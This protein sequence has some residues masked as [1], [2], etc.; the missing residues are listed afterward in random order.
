MPTLDWI[1]KKAVLNH[2]N[3]VP[4][5][6]L[7]EVPDLSVG[8][9]GNGN[10]LVE[11]D[12]LVA[13]KALLPYYAG[14]VK[15]IFIDPPYNSGEQTWTYNDYVSSPE[16]SRWL[17]K[18]VG[19]ESEDLSRHDKWLC[20]MYPRMRLLVQFLCLD[21]VMFVCLDDAE[22]YRFKLMMEEILPPSSFISALIWK[23]RR[24][25]DSRSKHNV[26]IDHEYVLAF[27]LGAGRFRGATK[28]MSKYSNPDNDP[29]GPWMSDN[30]VGLAT[31][32]R[33]PNLHYD[34]VNPQTGILYKCPGKGWRYSPE[35]MQRKIA[36]DRIIWPKN[37]SGRP[38]HK[39][40]LSDLESEFTG[41][42][43]FI[44]CGNTNE[45]T[46]EVQEILG[47][48]GFIF[49][50]PRS[51]IEQLVGQIALNENDIIM[52][53]FA[54]SGTTG[55]AVLQL[56]KQD[57]GNRRFILVEMDSNICR[58]VTAERLKRVCTGYD[59]PDGKQVEGLGGGFRYCKLGEACFDEV[60]RINPE[61]SFSDLARHV[62]F[63]ETGE[64]IMKQA[65]ANNPLI[66]VYKETAVY[67][68]YN[69]VLGDKQT[70]GGNVLTQAVLDH[71]PKHEG[72]KV[73]YGTACRFS[74]GRLKRENIVFKQIP[75]E[76]R[77]R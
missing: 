14:K 19:K 77:V 37:R 49:P 43:S 63:T 48:A 4:F 68:L 67:L 69:G 32:D 64:P 58:N 31:K 30:L 2:H 10:L 25:L 42:S 39:K 27:K 1:G 45:G 76:I 56:N 72:P 34:L 16:I 73:I 46:E 33:R 18:I 52:D 50:K 24:N 53:S 36:E 23:S 15:C 71:L 44:E 74:P 28:D 61:V 22:M 9:P 17:G 41:F 55:H 62:F 6:L 57:N 11:G 21:G 59:K 51:L 35:T 54:G 3:E 40:F 26:S 38:R 47:S 65:K 13:L 8:E 70:D 66:G 75:Y 7:K 60:G 5:H 29:R 12:N 20:M